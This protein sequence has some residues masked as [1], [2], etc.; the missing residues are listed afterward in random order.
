MPG[1]HP[2][3]V[4]HAI[5]RVPTNAGRLDP[6]WATSPQILREAAGRTFLAAEWCVCNSPISE[7]FRNSRPVGEERAFWKVR[8]HLEDDRGSILSAEENVGRLFDFPDAE[9]LSCDT[10]VIPYS[11]AAMAEIKRSASAVP[12]RVGS[13]VA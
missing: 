13:L 6:A 9:R 10:L 11:P 3:R 12:S 7:A 5:D 8:C 1:D 4:A 2:V